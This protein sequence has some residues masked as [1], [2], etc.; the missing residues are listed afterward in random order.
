MPVELTPLESLDPAALRRWES[1][2]A[3]A[4]EPNPFFDPGFVLPAARALARPGEVGLVHLEEQGD[5]VAAFPAVVGRWRGIVPAVASWRHKYSFLGTPLVRSG[6]DV[7]R[8]LR[9]ALPPLPGLAR[10]RTVVLEQLTADG[11]VTDAVRSVAQ[12]LR[13]GVALD[14]RRERAFLA[15]R[16]AGDYL[17][18]HKHQRRK[19]LGRLRRRLADSHGEVVVRDAGSDPDTVETALGR[20]LEVEQRGWKGD[21]GT[22]FASTPT[23]AAFFRGICE[24]FA[25]RGALELLEL[26]AGDHLAAVQCNL[27]SGAGVFTFKIAFDES[28]ARFSPGVLLVVD[29]IDRFHR[30][31]FAWMDSCADP[32]NPMINRLWQDRRALSSLALTAPGVVGTASGFALHA[33]GRM[34]ERR[35]GGRP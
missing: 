20:F 33:A 4:V 15:R 10:R 6:H 1:L 25:E 26:W 17:A 28:L 31:G 23:E 24:S 18:H 30:A 34:H 21:R 14:V 35:Q 11:P 22:A 12:E 32:Q 2:A 29:N 9:S 8:V 19:E 3:H 27:L 13:W 5:M 16:E 7:R